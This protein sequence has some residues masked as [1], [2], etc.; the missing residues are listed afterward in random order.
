MSALADITHAKAVNFA[1]EETQI[2]LLILLEKQ[3]RMSAQ[4]LADAPQTAMV[5]ASA[6][7]Q[8]RLGL[9]EM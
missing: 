6:P 3:Q 5:H 7:A 2:Q 1:A 9:L 8:R 4:L